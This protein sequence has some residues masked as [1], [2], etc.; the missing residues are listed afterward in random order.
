MVTPDESVG[1]MTVGVQVNDFI[2]CWVVGFFK[3]RDETGKLSQT[4]LL[5]AWSTYLADL[6]PKTDLIFGKK[7]SSLGIIWIKSPASKTF[8]RETYT[9]RV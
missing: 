4:V 6:Q 9:Q 2:I 3:N 5:G 7:T 8:D 1:G